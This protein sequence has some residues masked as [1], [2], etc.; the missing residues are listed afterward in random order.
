[1]AGTVLE[2]LGDVGFLYFC[3]ADLDDDEIDS[4]EKRLISE[5]LLSWGKDSVEATVLNDIFDSSLESF[6]NFKNDEY[7][8]DTFIACLT[9]LGHSFTKCNMR[10]LLQD[11]QICEH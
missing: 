4:E 2:I 11:L 10:S 5:K 3:V 1:M 7:P 9:R 8:S 6:Q